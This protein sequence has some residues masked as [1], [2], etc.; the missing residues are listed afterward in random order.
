MSRALE[1]TGFDGHNPLAFLAALGTLR[2]LT[3]A[4]PDADVRL[5]WYLHGAWHP[6]LHTARPLQQASLVEALHTELQRMERHPALDLGDNL[7]VPP[8]VFREYAQRAQAAASLN[9]RRWADFAVAFACECITRRNSKRQQVVETTALQLVSGQGHQDF[10]AIVRKIVDNT[11]ADHLEK[12]MFQPWRYDDPIKMQTM[13]WDPI[14]DIRYA[15]QWR[16]PE[17]DPARE[18]QGSMLGA[19]RLAFEG[20]P[21]LPTMPAGSELRTTGFTGQ[22]SRDTFWIWP[23]WQAPLPRDVVRSL[24]ALRE[25]QLPEPP[26]SM[27]VR[28]GVVEIYRSQRVTVDKYRNFT[29]AASV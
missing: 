24:L 17:A 28:R 21:L 2:T 6:I 25:L 22:S 23:I 27:L 5:S 1:L 15:L 16:N 8:V 13:R 29:P 20:L 12:A 26:R 7:G 18:K 10:L 14:D 4:W 11:T 19:N 3:L 9:D